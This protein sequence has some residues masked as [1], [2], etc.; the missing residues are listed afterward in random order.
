[1]NTVNFGPTFPKK[2]NCLLCLP[3]VIDFSILEIV[4]LSTPLILTR[5]NV[6]N[7]TYLEADLAPKVSDGGDR[8]D[9]R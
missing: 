4:V 9:A 6:P 1:M 5:S 8:K 2:T 7:A 3:F